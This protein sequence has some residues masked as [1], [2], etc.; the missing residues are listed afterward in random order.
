MYNQLEK[1]YFNHIEELSFYSIGNNFFQEPL[2]SVYV[3]GIYEIHFSISVYKD[4][5]ATLNSCI[6]IQ[7]LSE[8]SKKIHLKKGIN[9]YVFYACIPENLEYEPISKLD[10]PGEYKTLQ[11]ISIAYLLENESSTEDF[12]IQIIPATAIKIINSENIFFDI[13]SQ[14]KLVDKLCKDLTDHTHNPDCKFSLISIYGSSGIGKSYVLQ[15][16][17]NKLMKEKQHI[18]C[19]TYTFSGDKIDDIKVIKKLFFNCFSRIY[20]LRI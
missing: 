14:N 15:L 11:P 5:D 19:S 8:D 9:D 2:S 17:K 12:E 1:P 16:F 7:L 3:G 6:N 10:S 18:L 4:F 20:I 13:P